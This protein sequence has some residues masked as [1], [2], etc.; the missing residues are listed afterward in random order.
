MKEK[1]QQFFNISLFGQRE[2]ERERESV[3]ISS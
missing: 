3:I 2:R 1:A